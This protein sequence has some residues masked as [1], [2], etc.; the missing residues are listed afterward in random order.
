MSATLAG[1][2]SG[3]SARTSGRS[4]RLPCVAALTVLA[5]ALATSSVLPAS[6]V[7][8]TDSD[9]TTANVAVSSVITLTG[10]TS[11]FTLTG[12]PGATVATLNAVTMNVETN[13]VAGYDVTVEAASDVLDPADTVANPDTI[14]IDALSVREN[15]TPTYTQLSDTTPV[16]VHTQDSRSDDGGDVIGN[17]YSV[18]IPFVNVDTYSV[19]LNYIAT[20]L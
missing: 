12:I 6:A 1:P 16:T 17:D 8:L 10:L 19:T 11:G 3:R 14:P 7:P 18:D 15:G 5:A 2:R 4:Q 9:S 13:N 20:T